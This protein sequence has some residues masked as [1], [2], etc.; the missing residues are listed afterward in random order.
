M[1]VVALLATVLSL[2][3]CGAKAKPKPPQHAAVPDVRGMNAP[4]AA[5]RLI[6]ARYCVRLARGTPPADDTRPKPGKSTTAAQLPVERQSPPAGVT[7]RPWSMVTLTVGGISKHAS[8]FIAVW[9]GSAKI[10]CPAISTAP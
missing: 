4:D 6:D 10:P 3:A 7:R 8:S 9:E 5:A 1:K 2:T